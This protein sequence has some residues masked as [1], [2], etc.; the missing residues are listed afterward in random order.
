MDQAQ[1]ASPTDV[2][3]ILQRLAVDLALTDEPPAPI[4]G[5]PAPLKEGVEVLRAMR[6]EGRDGTDVSDPYVTVLA[7][8]DALRRRDVAEALTALSALD[9]DETFCGGSRWLRA[10]LAAPHRDLREAAVS[11]LEGVEVGS[12]GSLAKR[13]LVARAL[14][15]GDERAVAAFANDAGAEVLSSADRLVLAA[16]SAKSFGSFAF[17]RLDSWIADTARDDEYQT[18]AAAVSGLLCGDHAPA[19]TLPVGTP[20]HRAEVRLGRC[21]ASIALGSGSI[22]FDGAAATSHEL[23]AVDASHGA[24]RAVVLE[25]AFRTHR[26]GEVAEMLS[27]RENDGRL[28]GLL[29]H[30][31]DHVGAS[32]EPLA[33]DSPAEFAMR[34]QLG[35]AFEQSPQSE[36]LLRMAL[37]HCPEKTTA[38]GAAVALA[39]QAEA[40]EEPHAS[41]AA[42]REAALRYDAAGLSS[43]AVQAFSR[44]VAVDARWSLAHDLAHHIARSYA[45]D[46]AQ[47]EWLGRR[48]KCEHVEPAI[49]RLRQA[50]HPSNVTREGRDALLDEALALRP[51]DA[52]LRELHATLTGR[53]AV[54][55]P[56]DVTVAELAVEA[57]FGSE[58]DRDWDAMKAY[59]ERAEA[60]GDEL[61]A[62][63][64]RRRLARRGVDALAHAEQLHAA[65]RATSDPALKEELTLAAAYDLIAAG[66]DERAHEILK[67]ALELGGSSLALSHLLTSR[68]LPKSTDADLAAANTA[69]A[70]VVGGAEAVAHLKLA[71]RLRGRADL[72]ED[73]AASAH[74]ILQHL[75]NDPWSLRVLQADA[76][77]RRDA[78]AMMAVV[79]PIVAEQEGSLDAATLWLRAAEL[80]LMDGRDEMGEFLLD[81]CLEIWPRHLLARILRAKL[82]DRRGPVERAAEAYERL[83]LVCRTPSKRV[84]AFYRAA[85]LWLSRD[86]VEAKHNGRRLLESVTEIDAGYKDS[87]ELLRAIYMASGAKS[88][89]ADLLGARLDHVEDPD[90][91]T[92]L[93]VMRGKILA[94]TGSGAEAKAALAAALA[95]SPDN[96]EALRAYV[97]VC[98]VDRDWSSTE[99]ALLRLGRLLVDAEEQSA[100]YLQLGQLYDGPLGNTERAEK[101]YQEVIRIAPAEMRPREK[102]VSLY[103]RAGDPDKALAQ[104]RA[105]IDVTEDPGDQCVRTVRLAE[106]FEQLEDLEQAETVLVG[107]RRRFTKDAEPVRALVDFYRRQEKYAAADMLLGRA[108]AEVRRGLGAGRFETNLF[109]MTATVA[110]LRGD[111]DVAEV[112]RASLA[113]IH[114]DQVRLSGMNAAA[115]DPDNDERLAPSVFSRSFRQLLCYSRGIMDAAVPLDLPGL[116]A[117]LLGASHAE[118]SDQVRRIAAA[119]GLG[120]VTLL[121]SAA[122]ERGCVAVAGVDVAGTPPTIVFGE[123]LLRSDRVGVRDFLLRRAMKTL[124][125]RTAALVRTEPSDLGP[126]LAAFLRLHK[127]DF[128]PT[129]VDPGKLELFG[130][131]MVD[132]GG[133]NED[134][135]LVNLADE[136]IGSIGNRASG[137]RTAAQVWASRAALLATGDPFVAIDALA[138][139]SG[140]DAELPPHGP[141]RIKWIGRHAELRDLVAFTV[142]EDYRN[143]RGAGH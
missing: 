135:R 89:L 110:E 53:R 70:S 139:A 10:A 83:A 28:V 84:G 17:E 98:T 69:I 2:R 8:R 14:E 38:A 52:S 44:S 120:D 112:A 71:A 115:V 35:L 103:L 40:I 9:V 121:F 4:E 5:V 46:A 50:L 133:T 129:G 128:V 114:G 16:L 3:P 80:H 91:R 106:I 25:H 29:L 102:L 141:D 56:E 30:E 41:A 85:S 138:W 136:V 142:S 60:L 65:A 93:E 77:K 45:D 78:D 94:E 73:F 118:F 100:I 18:L 33:T 119:A 132:A 123:A 95:A 64:F 31:L 116:G 1:R 140:A 37:R 34:D 19:A 21:L 72:N 32:D 57:A 124:Q 122:L 23:L 113:A 125:A 11:A 74:E 90:R 105:M 127:P 130:Q 111:H 43:E 66:Q 27:D 62:P 61:F 99:Q 6:S 96:I 49:E 81:R 67:E 108:A 13:A 79:G 55:P 26:R 15:A 22:E 92:E 76:M 12:H 58:L 97:E 107:A 131:R 7:A 39:A 82:L 104:Q 42:W 137:L 109:A 24:G 88:D 47:H 59:T 20:R 134:P 48:A 86:D 75:P 117:T 68:F 63:M 36:L 54:C 101:A 143:L 87:F 126:L 51:N